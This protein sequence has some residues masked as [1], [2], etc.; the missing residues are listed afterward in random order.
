[1]SV[2]FKNRLQRYHK[3]SLDTLFRTLQFKR[4]VERYSSGSSGPEILTTSVTITG[5]DIIARTSHPILAPKSGTTYFALR[6]QNVKF[7]GGTV[8]FDNGSP[9]NISLGSGRG[10]AAN[11]SGLSENLTVFNLPTNTSDAMLAFVSGVMGPGE[12]LSI[13]LHA[14]SEPTVG[15]SDVVVDITYEL[16]DF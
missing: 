15:D 9:Y 4:G 12:A 7:K 16:K 10:V 1:M 13:N 3:E 11:S 14:G 8:A 5:A 6:Q 2:P